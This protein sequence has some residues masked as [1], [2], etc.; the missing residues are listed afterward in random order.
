M[1]NFYSKEDNQKAHAVFTLIY[2]QIF[3]KKNNNPK[4]CKITLLEG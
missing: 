3:M 4:F 1:N 2:V